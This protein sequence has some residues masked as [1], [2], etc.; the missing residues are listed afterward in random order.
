MRKLKGIILSAVVLSLLA[1]SAYKSSAQS[2]NGFQTIGRHTVF[3]SVAWQGKP[4][5]GFGY[6]FR[7]FDK[8]FVDMQAE[9]RFPLAEM[10]KFDNF[11]VIAGAYKPSRLART[12]FGIGTHLRYEKTTTRSSTTKSLDFAVTGMPGIVYAQNTGG[13]VDGSIG[14]RIAYVPRIVES[15]QGRRGEPVIKHFKASQLELGG[16]ADFHVERTLYTTLNGYFTGHFDEDQK[17]KGAGADWERE[18][19]FYL[20]ATYSLD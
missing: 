6:N 2:F 19:N 18:G 1:G 17:K 20:G 12:F 9:M 16:H 3:F 13:G 4:Y 11:Q 15:S 7:G 14:L 8:S 5:L 10:Y